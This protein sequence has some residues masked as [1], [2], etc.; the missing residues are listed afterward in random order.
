MTSFF[1]KLVDGRHRSK[2]PQ[3][4]QIPHYQ[5]RYV[6]GPP[7]HED[8]Y[9]VAPRNNDYSSN[10]YDYLRAEKTE[11]IHHKWADSQEVGDIKRV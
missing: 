7:P 3:K 9:S 11:E 4:Q 6:Y 10:D 2:S 5:T 8:Q 1:K